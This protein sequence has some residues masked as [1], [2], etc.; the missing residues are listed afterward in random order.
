MARRASDRDTYA[1]RRASGLCGRCGTPTFEGAPLCG[2]CTVL[3]ARYQPKK[4]DANRARYAERRARWIC[5][6]CGRR[7]AFGASRCEPCAKRAYERSEHVRGLP[8]YPPSYTVIERATDIDHG[9]WD[10]WEDV[11]LCLAF[12]RLSL[13]EVDVLIDQSPMQTLTGFS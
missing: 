8:L 11:A 1:A 12:A 9:T 13:D 7:P 5:T 4:M 6:R 10:S 2:P 3:E